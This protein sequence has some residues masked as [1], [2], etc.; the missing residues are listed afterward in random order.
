[1][2]ITPSNHDSRDELIHHFRKNGNSRLAD[3]LER[4][5]LSE[6]LARCGMRKS[7]KPFPFFHLFSER[8]FKTMYPDFE[9]GN[10]RYHNLLVIYHCNDRYN[11]IG[12]MNMKDYSED[13]CLEFI[14][15]GID[16]W[17][18]RLYLEDE[19]YDRCLPYLDMRF[20]AVTQ[21]Q[22]FICNEWH[23]GHKVHECDPARKQ[24]WLEEQARMV[25]ENEL[26]TEDW[27]EHTIGKALFLADER[28]SSPP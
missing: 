23:P 5:P 4:P 28:P 11:G 18:R 19:V 25:R 7:P 15:N 27:I 20:E 1:M 9:Q 17:A 8:H 3:F 16:L 2:T 26:S 21:Y 24:K 14:H 13:E 6:T 12:L 10:G 22:C